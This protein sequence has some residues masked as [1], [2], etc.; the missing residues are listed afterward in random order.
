M[1]SIGM[2]P[3]DEKKRQKKSPR[4]RRRREYADDGR[5]ITL[6]GKST[7]KGGDN[8][9][10][11]GGD[12]RT[13]RDGDD[14]TMIDDRRSRIEGSVKTGSIKKGAKSSKHDDHK[15]T[16]NAKSSIGKKDTI[17]SRNRGAKSNR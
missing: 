5:T 8:R 3:G 11:R 12:G 15:T 16:I 7:I 10:I 14:R 13:I 4:A 6:D 9:T 2:A 17:E 1:A